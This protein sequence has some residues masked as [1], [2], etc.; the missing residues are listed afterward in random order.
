M[1]VMN[2]ERKFRKTLIQSYHCG[3][4]CLFPDRISSQSKD[5]TFPRRV[6]IRLA[7]GLFL[8]SLLLA[9]RALL[10]SWRCWK[11][12]ACVF[13]EKSFLSF[14]QIVKWVCDTKSVKTTN[15]LPSSG[16]LTLTCHLLHALSFL[17]FTIISQSRYWYPI[18]QMRTLQLRKMK[19]FVL[20][21]QL[22][23]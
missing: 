5:E 20:V 4:K 8:G 9:V 2:R 10:A 22:I 13:S 6:S 21:A 15:N 16:Y 23:S 1:R 12:C 14:C 18:L 17:I 19:L 11:S 3:T 7:L